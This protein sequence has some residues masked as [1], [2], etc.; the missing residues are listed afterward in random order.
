MQK[1]SPDSIRTKTRVLILLAAAVA[2]WSSPLTAQ[3]RYLTILHWNDFHSQDSPFKVD[4]VDSSTG[5]KT[6]YLVGG[7]A[8]L[9]GLIDSLRGSRRDLLVLNAGD[10]FQGTPISTV[11]KGRSQIE[12]MNIIHPDAVTLGNHEFDYDYS[13]LRKQLR[14]AKYPIVVANLLNSATRR[15]V[16]R[17]C[18]VKD[19]NGLRVAVI[20]VTTPELPQL[21]LP[22]NIIGLSVVSPVPVVRAII[23]SLRRVRHPNLVVVLSHMGVDADRMLADSVETIDVIIGG[24]SHTALFRPVKQKRTIICQA[25]SRGRYLG[26]LDLTVDVTGDSIQSYQGTLIE[27]RNGTVTPDTAAARLVASFERRID[28]SFNRPIGTVTAD[29]TVTHG[30]ESSLGDW[31][32][33]VMRRYSKTDIALQNS[34]GIRR[35]ISAGTICVRDLWEVNPFDNTFV[36]F[37][38]RGDTL[39]MMMAKQVERKTEL[40]QV[41]G[42]R[43]SFSLDSAG[44][45]LIELTVGDKPVVDTAHYSVVT[46]DFVGAHL[47]DF[48]GVPDSTLRVRDLGVR[49]RDVFIEA[50]ERDKVIHP[51]TDGRIKQVS[52]V[53]KR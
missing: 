43:Y 48:F 14:L 18:L 47:G 1:P 22:K 26:R 42:L 53:E 23:D 40:M 30:E 35:S 12:L 33:D 5:V 13:S 36:T 34:G 10:D 46:N 7:S 2:A 45:R 31:E 15:R 32:A 27:T 51:S 37:S 50:V 49:D 29:W 21:T 20:G 19:V 16:Y 25:G 17:S 28:A 4:A 39:R 3:T 52:E 8:V 24:H 41:S 11:T 9:F 6:S 38:V 44:G